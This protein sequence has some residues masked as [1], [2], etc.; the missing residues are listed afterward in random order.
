LFVSKDV[1]VHFYKSY[2]YLAG[3]SFNI[4]LAPHSFLF[5]QDFNYNFIFIYLTSVSALRQVCRHK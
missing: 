5:S 4:F 3:N 2:H 1:E